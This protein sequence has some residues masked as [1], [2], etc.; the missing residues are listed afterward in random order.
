MRITQFMDIYIHARHPSFR[1]IFAKKEQQQQQQKWEQREPYFIMEKYALWPLPKC[2]ADE[3]HFDS[4]VYAVCPANNEFHQLFKETSDTCEGQYRNK[5]KRRTYTTKQQNHLNHSE[6]QFST[7]E[8]LWEKMLM[9]SIIKIVIQLYCIEHSY[10]SC[11]NA[12]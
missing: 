8:L 11:L 4:I 10:G 5:S 9:E 6:T 7:M 12:G 1:I 3:C 2:L